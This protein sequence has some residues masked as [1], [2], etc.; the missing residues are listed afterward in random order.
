MADGRLFAKGEKGGKERAIKFVVNGSP[1]ALAPFFSQMLEIKSEEEVITIANRIIVRQRIHE[2]ADY[3]LELLDSAGEHTSTIQILIDEVILSIISSDQDY[4]RC[5]DL[6][7]RKNS[8]ELDSPLYLRLDGVRNSL[9]WERLL[10]ERFPGYY[11]PTS[12]SV[13]I[14]LLP[15]DSFL[16]FDKLVEVLMSSV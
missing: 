8:G 12:K 13:M 15:A 2:V 9:L 5:M 1:E 11:S 10:D 7:T 14:K 16:N 4:D 6:I 3:L